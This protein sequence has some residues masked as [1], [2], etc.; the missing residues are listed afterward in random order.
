MSHSPNDLKIEEKVPLAPLTTFGVGGAARFYVRAE[1]E[2]QVVAALGFA[3]EYGFDVFVLGGGSNVLIA[4][5]GF[6]G[7]VLRVALKGIAVDGPRVTAGAG[8]DWDEFCEFCVANELAGIECLSGIPGTVG[9]T[10]V[11]NVGA[12][13]QEVSETIVRV[14]VFDRK[15]RELLDLGRDEC[16]FG[17]RASIFNTTEK[18]R[19]VV[20]AVTFELVPGGAPKIVYEDLRAHFGDRR[21]T[22]AETRE[23]VRTIRAQ[24]AMLVRQGGPDANSAGSFFK[25]PVVSAERFAKL[26][27]TAKSDGIESVPNFPG[28]DGFC[29][30]PAAWLIEKSGFH[31]GYT[32]GRA[33]LSTLHTLALTNRGD[34]TAGEIIALKNEIQIAVRNKFGIELVPEP[35]FVGF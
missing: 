15:T 2:A 21:P 17:Y 34:A 8:E 33:G 9:G 14:R 35:V 20:L 26:L 4:D 18:N 5:G 10:P 7:L 23:A 6:D 1:T 22:L 12:Y 31:K 3:A 19:F 32:L 13:G 28:G 24:K 30:I 16:R 29:K 11:Q 25:N 27:E